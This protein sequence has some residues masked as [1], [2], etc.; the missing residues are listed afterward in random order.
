MT[1][2]ISSRTRILVGDEGIRKLKD[3]SIIVCGCGAVGGYA[4]EALVRAGVGKIRA[5]D[6][7]VFSPS[8]L[9]RQILCTESTVGRVKSEVAVERARSIN[10]GIDIEGLDSYISDDTAETI[11]EGDWDILVDAIDTIANKARIDCAALN[12]GLPVFA[13]MGAA[14]HLDPTKVHVATLKDTK[15]CPLAAK[16]RRQMRDVDTK[17]MLCV[18]SEEPVPVKPAE[19][20]EHGKSV[21]G[22]LPTVPGIFGFTLAGLAIDRIL[23]ERSTEI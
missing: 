11:L 8:N 2:D 20:D 12:K 22:S 5:V 3:A 1:E 7:D 14:M 10:P 13:S 23:K 4:I 18:Y 9:N 16:L 19:R 21:L 6:K 15:V 17:N